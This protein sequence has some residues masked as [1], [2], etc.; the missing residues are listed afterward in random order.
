M[1]KILYIGA[2]NKK[3]N[4]ADYRWN[5]LLKWL[6]SNCNN[7]R[8][9][10]ELNINQ[11]E[12]CFSEYSNILEENFPDPNSD[13]KGYR[14]FCKDKRLWEQIATTSYK[15]DNGISHI[16]FLKDE[17]Y[18]A[19]LAVDDCENFVLLHL[20]KEEERN[21]IKIMPSLS[22]NIEECNYWKEQINYLLDDELWK[23]LGLE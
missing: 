22:E 13:T 8:I 9:Y 20:T 5:I 6:S 12:S 7:I 10:T 11:I 16:Y 1:I 17:L 18:K 14:L 15:I 23:P 2:V 21:L 3:G 4:F 19:E